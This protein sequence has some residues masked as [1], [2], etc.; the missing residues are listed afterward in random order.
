ML[1]VAFNTTQQS[2][3]GIIT[4]NTELK[5]ATARAKHISYLPRVDMTIP[6]VTRD[7]LMFA[8]SFS[9]CPTAPLEVARSLTKIEE[10]KKELRTQPYLRIITFFERS[11]LEYK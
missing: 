2:T 6:K 9:L 5:S 1:Q 8:P 3:L 7:L 11:S 4:D 10:K